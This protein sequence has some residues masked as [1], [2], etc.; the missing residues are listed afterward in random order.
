MATPADHPQK[1][2]TNRFLRKFLDILYETTVLILLLGAIALVHKFLDWWLGPDAKLLDR[3]PVKYII[4]VGHI[5][6][7]IRFLIEIVRDIIEAVRKPLEH[8]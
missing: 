6:A 5:L 8:E 2:K 7:I 3:V 1:P 4:D